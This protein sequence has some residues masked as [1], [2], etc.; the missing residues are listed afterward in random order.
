MGG[1]TNHSFIKVKNETNINREKSAA[2]QLIVH[3][4]LVIL[5]KT[6]CMLAMKLKDSLLLAS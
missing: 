5:H 4:C 2:K 3:S 6:V 1:F